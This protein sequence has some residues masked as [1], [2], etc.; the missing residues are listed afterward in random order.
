LGAL[1]DAENAQVLDAGVA[2]GV[3]SMESYA[4]GMTD[5]PT[6]EAKNTEGVP[7]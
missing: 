6:I 5:T 2:N 1:S 7:A 3:L 4:W